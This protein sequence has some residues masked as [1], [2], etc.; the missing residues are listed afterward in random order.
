MEPLKNF[1][2]IKKEF[3]IYNRA[4]DF[5]IFLV[6]CGGTGGIMA[7]NICR[8]ANSLLFLEKP[9][10][11]LTI[12]DHDVVEPEDCVRQVFNRNEVGLKKS[13]VISQHLSRK[14]GFEVEYSDEKIQDYKPKNYED[15]S[16]IFISCVD[17]FEARK[18]IY[19]MNWDYLIDCGNEKDFGQ[20]ILSDKEK[21]LQ[22][23][24]DLF[25]ESTIKSQSKKSKYTCDIAVKLNE[26]SLFINHA[27]ALYA[28]EMLKDF[29]FED[30]MNYNQ[31]FVNMKTGKTVKHLKLNNNEKS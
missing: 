11:Q 12:I 29:I 9:S 2:P 26:Q 10:I 13:K 19:E 25:G 18:F 30:M 17:N 20:I 15:N 16:K 31:V 8:I 3:S 23:L 4:H 5:N 21:E 22:S 27:I 14:W 6:G 28:S 24:F 1:F 7:D